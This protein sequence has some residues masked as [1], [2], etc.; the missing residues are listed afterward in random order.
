[1]E[2]RVAGYSNAPA[3]QWGSGH[4]LS[5][6]P[7]L[8]GG[9]VVLQVARREQTSIYNQ[10]IPMGMMPDAMIPFAWYLTRA[11]VIIGDAES[12]ADASNNTQ[13][14]FYY[15]LTADHTTGTLFH[16]LN[17]VGDPAAGEPITDGLAPIMIQ[18]RSRVIFA[19]ITRNGVGSVNM[20]SSTFTLGVDLRAYRVA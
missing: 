6:L 15:G 11:Y 4:H 3:S 1:M 8:E 7:R 16:T 13:I 10:T 20:A 12:G 5:A 9:Y 18:P 14:D 2:T 17:T 19:R